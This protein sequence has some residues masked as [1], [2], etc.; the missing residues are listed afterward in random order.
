MTP[1]LFGTAGIRGVT[2]ADIT[3][4]L[5]VRLARAYGD[6]IRT[7][8]LRHRSVAVGHDTRWGSPMLARAASAGFASAGFNVRYTGCVPTG[9]FA[10]NVARTGQDG[11]L[12]VTGSHMPPDRVGLLLATA[13]GAIA[14]FSL[15]DPVEALLAAGPPPEVPPD[16]VGRIEDAA[17]PFEPYLAHVLQ[18]VDASLVRSKNYR[19][20]VDPANGTAGPVGREFFRRLGASI[21]MIHANPGPVPARPSEPRAHTVGE[22]IRK[23]RETSSDLGACFDV[24]A[25][26]ALFIGRDGTPLSEDA[27]GALFARDLL[28]P[29]D[30]CVVPVNSSG[31]IEQ[32]CRGIGARLEYCAIGQSSTIQA[33]RDLGAAFSYE[34]SGKYWFARR[35]LWS[36]SLYSTAKLLEIMA[37]TGRS[38]AELAAALPRFYQSKRNVPV[39]EERKDDLMRAVAGRLRSSLIDDRLRDLTLDGFKRVY[40]DGAWVLFRKSGTEPLVRVYSDAPSRERAEGLATAGEAL[41]KECL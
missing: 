41:L 14:P 25:D 11:G 7:H 16:R 1:R 35:F 31:L 39:D 30:A 13:D 28:S 17:D 20:L 32:V 38:A 6:W 36:D 8:A 5:A 26:R 2:N 37:R 9:A 15:T 12:Y 23:V 19:L 24:D 18:D 3:P 4:E 22:A 21:E 29:G 10:A 40:R 34:E 27:V 33:I